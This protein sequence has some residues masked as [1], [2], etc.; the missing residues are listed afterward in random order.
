ME[1]VGRSLSNETPEVHVPCAEAEGWAVVHC[2][3]I[4]IEYA[5]EFAVLEVLPE[6][7]T[8]SLVPAQPVLEVAAARPSSV[9]RIMTLE[10]GAA[11]WQAPKDAAMTMVADVPNYDMFPPRRS[12]RESPRCPDAADG[13]K[14]VLPEVS[15]LCV[16]ATGF[17]RNSGTVMRALGEFDPETVLK[18]ASLTASPG[19]RCFS[20]DELRFADCS[21]ARQCGPPFDAPQIAI[22][23]SSPPPSLPRSSP[24]PPPSSCSEV[25]E[26]TLESFTED[27]K[28]SLLSGTRS[29]NRLANAHCAATRTLRQEGRLSTCWLS[30]FLT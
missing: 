20:A 30:F 2:E 1:A 4:V 26:V 24:T 13:T 23:R 6:H 17:H 15:F 27:V 18:R 14:L 16:A 12:A 25:G 22:S 21:V 11:Q 5:T 8:Q 10:A 28:V 3:E 9:S 19:F 29:V 7:T